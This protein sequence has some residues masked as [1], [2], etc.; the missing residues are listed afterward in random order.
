MFLFLPSR[1]YLCCCSFTTPLATNGTWL[2]DSNGRDMMTR[3]RNFRKY[4]NYTVHEPVA[5]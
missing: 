2:T 4:W 5:G 3:V 1:L